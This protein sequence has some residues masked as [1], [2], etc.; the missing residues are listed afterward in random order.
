MVKNTT[1]A[2]VQ[3]TKAPETQRKMAK[4]NSNMNKTKLATYTAPNKKISVAK[5]T[6]RSIA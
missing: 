2:K 3:T 5:G 1:G 6:K 4:T